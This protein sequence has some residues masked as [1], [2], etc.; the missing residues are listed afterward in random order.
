MRYKN[1]IGLVFVF[2][3][4]FLT[5]CF[6]RTLVI[7]LGFDT[8]AY[9]QL[10]FH[11]DTNF[12][13]INVTDTVTFFNLTNLERGFIKN[14]NISDDNSSLIVLIPGIYEVIGFISFSDGNNQQFDLSAL[15]NGIETDEVQAH[16]KLGAGGDVGLQGSEGL[17]NLSIG[18]HI[19][20]ALQHQG[21]ASVTVNVETA[22]L[23]I[24]LID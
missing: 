15:I 22:S 18:D 9:G 23:V 1:I 19:S 16:R 7:D 5:G 24:E 6:E 8:V 10:W 12:L 13:I 4:L 14:F 2:L 11:N 20:L 3:T 21:G 17:L